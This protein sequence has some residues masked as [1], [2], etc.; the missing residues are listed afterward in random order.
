MYTICNFI[1][2]KNIIEMKK[3][4]KNLRFEIYDTQLH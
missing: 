4:K 1:D 2:T 3:L